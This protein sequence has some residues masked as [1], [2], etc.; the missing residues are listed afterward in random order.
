MAS[1]A[2]LAVAGGAAP[3]GDA[4]V[5][6]AFPDL[7]PLNWLGEQAA[8]LASD[9]WKNAMIGL[10]SAGL[11]MLQLAFR[12]I[13]ALTVP[14]LSASGPLAGALP[15]T[16]WL[17]T[18]VAALMLTVQLGSALVRQDGSSVGR[19]LLGAAQ[20]GAVWVAFLGV[21][22]LLVV[23]AGALTHGIL[24]SMLN[25]DSWSA[26]GAGESWPRSINDATAA[27]VLGL[28]SL[29]LL[30]PAS[31]GYLI[32]MLV[33]EGALII[34]VATAP[35][36][37]AG[38]LSDSTKTWFWKSLRWFIA[39]LLIAPFAALIL[40]VG[41][42]VSSGVVQGA[43]TDTVAAVGTAVVGCVLVLLGAVCPMV[44]FKLLAFVEPGTS[45]GMALRQSM[46][47]TG[48]MGGLMG[49]GASAGGS[50]SAATQGDGSGRS[51]GEASAETQ[52]SSRMA[53]MLGGV[54]VGA[55]IGTGV[56][57]AF[58][59]ADVATDVLGSA[60]IGDSGYGGMAEQ[61]RTGGG[62][63]GSSGQSGQDQA[64]SGGMQPATQPGA[65]PGS[66]A[67]PLPPP[68]PPAGPAHSGTSPAGPV[69]AGPMPGGAGAAGAGGAGAGGAVE[70]AAV[71]A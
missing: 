48:G 55:V 7:N 21:A 59:A 16:L 62:G 32:I 64:P 40:G 54:G 45:S 70:A 34:L 38:L 22:G 6:L 17:G 31:L 49:G 53:G 15:T 9:A 42:Q 2:W 11:W 19:V 63:S 1:A 52:T 57:L 35:I 67:P 24:G 33:R 61:R 14:D 23:A 68:G 27:S 20:F 58:R 44:L 4:G 65:D 3:G 69:P 56:A 47:D 28:S 18:S 30:L 29:L 37:A 71:L 50:S 26:Y 5:T 46:S 13:D 12:V 66:A 43:G 60:G 10:W 36:S 51:A 25:V 39:T 41:V 8:G